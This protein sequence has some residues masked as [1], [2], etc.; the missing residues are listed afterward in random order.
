VVVPI[1]LIKP[2]LTAFALLARKADDRHSRLG[3]TLDIDLGIL[4]AQLSPSR[5]A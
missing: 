2:Q 3:G 5:I 1:V 4:D